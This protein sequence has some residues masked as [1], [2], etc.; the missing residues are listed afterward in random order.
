MSMNLK[1]NVVEM[2]DGKFKIFNLNFLSKHEDPIDYGLVH[3]NT[4]YLP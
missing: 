3:D 1:L 2:E 4:Q